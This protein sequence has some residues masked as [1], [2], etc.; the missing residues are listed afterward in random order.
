MCEGGLSTKI[1]TERTRC[2]QGSG[3]GNE[4]ETQVDALPGRHTHPHLEGGF[5]ALFP[6]SLYFRATGSVCPRPEQLG[7]SGKS[8]V[9]Q[10]HGAAQYRTKHMNSLLRGSPSHNF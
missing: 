2:L 6:I 1:E 3:G 5:A 7:D 9:K 10:F 8:F 4:E